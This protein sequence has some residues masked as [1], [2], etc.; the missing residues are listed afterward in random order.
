MKGTDVKCPECGTINTILLLDE[1]E[2]FYEC[3]NFVHC[4]TVEGY[5]RIIIRAANLKR[6][7]AGEAIRERRLTP[8]PV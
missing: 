5:R 3:A 4:G 7:T 8:L 2:G 6:D 1:T